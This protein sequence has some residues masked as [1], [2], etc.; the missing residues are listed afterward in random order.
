MCLTAS[1]PQGWSAVTVL[2]FSTASTS[3]LSQLILFTWTHLKEKLNDAALREQELLYL[4]YQVGGYLTRKGYS[5]K[6]K[7]GKWMGTIKYKCQLSIS[8]D[9]PNLIA[10]KTHICVFL[11]LS[12]SFLH[13]LGYLTY[14]PSLCTSS[15]TQPSHLRHSA[16]FM[17]KTCKAKS[18]KRDT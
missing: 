15:L 10:P 14:H 3:G 6:L 11:T 8:S 16:S 17:S 1:G 5:E 9:K 13:N 4:M 18:G 12:D 7:Q 2:M